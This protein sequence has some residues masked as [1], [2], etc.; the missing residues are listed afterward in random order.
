[1]MNTMLKFRNNFNTERYELILFNTTKQLV[2][3]SSKMNICF[4]MG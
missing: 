2:I 4:V 3:L 1:M